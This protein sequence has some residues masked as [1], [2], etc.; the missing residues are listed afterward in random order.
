[1]IMTYYLHHQ[2]TMMTCALGAPLQALGA[3]PSPSAPSS[4]PQQGD[5][6]EPGQAAA[7]ACLTG[8]LAQLHLTG[9]LCQWAV[10]V[11]LHVPDLPGWP[12]VR[13]HLVEGLLMQSCEEW[14]KDQDKRSFLTNVLRLPEVSAD[15]SCRM[16]QL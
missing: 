7:L 5:A 12:G 8:L 6:L 9:G 2:H 11:A 14:A 15:G 16:H 10:Y 4:D 1:M 13:R 3:L